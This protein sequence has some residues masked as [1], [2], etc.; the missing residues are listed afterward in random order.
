MAAIK[1][2]TPIKFD[3]TSIQNGREIKLTEFV[4][5]TDKIEFEYQFKLDNDNLKL[6]IKEFSWIVRDEYQS[7]LEKATETKAVSFDVP[8]AI[9]YVGDWSFEIQNASS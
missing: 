8:Y 1:D 9:Q 2:Q 7:A 5:T 4:A 6:H 3:L